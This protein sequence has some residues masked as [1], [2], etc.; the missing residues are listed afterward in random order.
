[1]RGGR[2][3]AEDNPIRLL[4]RYNTTSLETVF[5]NLCKERNPPPQAI[6]YFVNYG[7]NEKKSNYV[8]ESVTR[9][10]ALVV[11]N[12]VIML[13]NLFM[14]LFV[15]VIPA[16]MVL[17]IG[18]AS[19]HD[20]MSIK[21]GVVNLETDFYTCFDPLHQKV[22]EGECNLE[23][24]GCQFLQHI[25]SE[26]I[27]LKN[28]AT[29]DDAIEDVQK[30][31]ISG[32][33]TIPED[34][35]NSFYEFVTSGGLVDDYVLNNSQIIVRLDKTTLFIAGSIEKT[36]YDTLNAYTKKILMNCGF[37]PRQVEYPLQFSEPVFGNDKDNNMLDS[38]APSF[39]L[40]M[41]IFFPVLSSSIRFIGEKK[42]GTL[43]R[44][45][46]SGTNIWEIVVAYTVSE[47]ALIVAQGG[48]VLICLRVV[49]GRGPVGSLELSLIMCI[50][51]GVCGM[52]FGFLMGITLSEEIEAGLL[53]MAIFFPNIF[54][55]GSMWPAESMPAVMRYVC[56][57]LPCTM[58]TEAFRSIFNR[59]WDFTH[60][61][62]WSGFLVISI[63]ISVIILV[64]IIIHRMKTNL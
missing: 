35:S 3:I 56:A 4:E 17:T 43:G 30:G 21:V 55:S 14:L 1:M 38:V 22:V 12:T 48:L 63:Y 33:L 49:I 6:E 25:P 5:L 11:K 29:A 7:G 16:A 28:Y 45:L 42:D 62:V 40:M 34:Y 41:I 23:D 44:S 24:L 9:V 10:K 57:Y 50:M 2:L 51:I 37:D 46:V 53:A 39:G 31:K 27:E 58:S 61:V 54:L 19:K 52:T 36:M 13:R 64:T 15:T 20:P 60:P 47:F 8:Q 18:V 26:N 32:F 59:G